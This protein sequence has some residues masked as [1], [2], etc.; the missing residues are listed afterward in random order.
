MSEFA[1]SKNRDRLEVLRL[2]L[3]KDFASG[4]EWFDENGLLVRNICRNDV[5][6]FHWK[7]QV[8]CKRAVVIHDTQDSS[9]RTMGSQPPLAKTANGPK[10]IGRTRNINF[11]ADPPSPPFL[12]RCS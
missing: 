7:C 9:A 4:S 10:V 2:D 12:L 8:F 11:P 6:V 3:L 5:Q 1:V